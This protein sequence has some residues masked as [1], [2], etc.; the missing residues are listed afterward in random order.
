MVINFSFFYIEYEHYDIHSPVGISAVFIVVPCVLMFL[1][2]GGSSSICTLLVQ[3]VL[4]QCLLL[5]S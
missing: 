2:M 4:L 1:M 5:F 3:F